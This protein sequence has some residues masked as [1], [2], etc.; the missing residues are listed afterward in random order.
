MAAFAL[1]QVVEPVMH[2]LGL[3]DWVLQAVVI[4]LGLG[5]PVTALLAWAYDLGAT[6]IERTP[7]DGKGRGWRT[8]AL[9]LLGLLLAAPGVAWY[10]VFRGRPGTAPGPSAGG[11]SVAVLPLVNVSGEAENEYFSD[12]LSEEIL[13]TLAQ[14]PGLRV[15][16][17]TSSFAFKGKALDVGRIA[18]ALHVAAVL[19]GSV[20]K[21]GGRIRVTV[22]LVDA[23]NGYHLW[24][25]TFDRELKD[26]FAIQDEISRAIAA[27]LELKLAPAGALP[28]G[29]PGATTNPAAYESYLKGRQALGERNPA[30]I[31]KARAHFERAVALD[32]GF[33]MALADEAMAEVML[34]RDEYGSVPVPQAVARARASLERAR[35]LAPD[36]PEVLGAVGLIELEASRPERALLALDRALQQNPSSAEL[37]MWRR[38]ALLALGRYDEALASIADAIQVDPLSKIALLNYADDLQRFGRDE[39]VNR[40]VARLRAIDESWGL[41]ALGAIAAA[42]GD[43]VDAVR[44]LVP[45]LQ[46]GREPVEP[47]LGQVLAEVGLREEALSV[48]KNR[49]IDVVAALGDFSQVLQR[50]REAAEPSLA[51]YTAQTWYGLGLYV[52]GR[53]A[54]AASQ[55]VS[56]LESPPGPYLPPSTLAVLADAAR[57]GGQA[58]EAA[59]ARELAGTRLAQQAS[60]GMLDLY[61]DYARAVLAAYD[62]RDEDAAR[63]ITGLAS[64]E[65][66][67]VGPADLRMPVFSRLSRRPDFLAAAGRLDATLSRQ[68]DEVVAM[69]CGSRRVSP[70]WQP[71]PATCA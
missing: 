46:Q 36:N 41:Q 48:A 38:G 40:A 54:E 58:V 60:A 63:R 42:R 8:A 52:T 39:E 57:R 28:S 17:R 7:S 51:D 21:V 18:D 31:E 10:V 14:V 27:A 9:V 29:R 61:L 66:P 32:P 45:A 35:A 5:L 6:G 33:A 20:R 47:V 12:G 44:H 59:K 64:A 56:V 71:Q 55:A 30:S 23:R 70:T 50:S 4:G 37:R 1:L 11:P 43:R 68:R 53:T 16:A 22:Q 24:S 62:G 13:N 15:P 3:P 69:L 2:G 34:S 65:H 19:E 26:V 67:V 49:P 25:Q